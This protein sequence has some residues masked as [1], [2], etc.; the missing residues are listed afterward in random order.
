MCC[1]VYSV[2]YGWYVFGWDVTVFSD[3]VMSQGKGRCFVMMRLG[4]RERERER[5]M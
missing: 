4:E 5:C 2:L 3:A 1:K